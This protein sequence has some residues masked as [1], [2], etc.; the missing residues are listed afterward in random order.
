[1]DRKIATIF[2]NQANLQLGQQY[3]FFYNDY[4]QKIIVYVYSLSSFEIEID[5]LSLTTL[6]NL[7]IDIGFFRMLNL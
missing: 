4:Y 2:R 1:M 7:Y 5:I 6:I 3:R